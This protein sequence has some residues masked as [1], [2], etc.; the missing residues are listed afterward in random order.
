M[1]SVDLRD[2]RRAGF[3]IG[4]LLFWGGFGFALYSAYCFVPVYVS[5]ARVE[6]A[7]S[8]VLKYGDHTLA[9][10]FLR[11]RAQKA[12]AS[13][14]Y[15]PALH[16][17]D[18]WHDPAPGKRTIHVVFDLPIT[19]SYL[20]ADRTVTRRVHAKRTWP[21]NEAD[22]TRL[23]GEREDARNAEESARRE[24]RAHFA[25]YKSRIQA[26]CTQHNTATS[27]V[28]HITFTQDDGNT[29]IVPCSTAMNWQ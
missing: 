4:K 16:Q 5:H 23:A 12:S 7:I 18:V 20:G 9:D 10:S 28:T 25:D 1:K 22:E 29:Q 26:E 24:Q 21:V 17:I 3:S 11:D 14:S 6:G 27:Y 15:E 13:V 2:R 19:V 8:N